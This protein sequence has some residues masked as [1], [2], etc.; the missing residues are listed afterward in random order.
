MQAKRFIGGMDK[1]KAAGMEITELTPEQLK[2]FREAT[3]SVYDTIGKKEVGEQLLNKV[4]KA[5]QE[6]ESKK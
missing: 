1:L 4:L 5:V 6:A 2:S 3:K